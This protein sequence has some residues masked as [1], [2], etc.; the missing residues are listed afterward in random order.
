MGWCECD[1]ANAALLYVMSIDCL[2]TIN[3]YRTNFLLILFISS[4]LFFS[5][6]NIRRNSLNIKIGLK[7]FDKKN[8]ASFFWMVSRFFR[9]HIFSFNSSKEIINCF[10]FILH[11]QEEVWFINHHSLTPRIL[12]PAFYDFFWISGWFFKFSIM[13]NEYPS[14]SRVLQKKPSGLDLKTFD[15]FLLPAFI[16]IKCQCRSSVT[17]FSIIFQK[18]LSSSK[19]YLPGS[20]F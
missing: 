2:T 18:A 16:V 9:I 20:L 1:C 8:I 7:S 10:I 5:S 17:L 14:S 12:L 6:F 15:L 11:F 19:S 3:D 4:T 13:S